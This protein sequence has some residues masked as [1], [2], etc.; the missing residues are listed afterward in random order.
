M[1][2]MKSGNTAIVTGAAGGIGL[3]SAKRFA[4]AGMNVGLVDMEADAQKEA[5]TALSGGAG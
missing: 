1:N 3:E 2:W 4:A 5:E